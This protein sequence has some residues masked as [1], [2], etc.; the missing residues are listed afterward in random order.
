M[1][2]TET[3]SFP[4]TNH[5]ALGGFQS[6][7]RFHGRNHV[8]SLAKSAQNFSKFRFALRWTEAFRT[9]ALFA[10]PFGDGN[11]RFSR[12]RASRVLG[13]AV[14][15]GRIARPVESGTFAALTSPLRP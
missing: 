9:C 2:L 4:P 11:F 10:K 8:S 3:F 12:R 13:G 14:T 5:F 15:A 1:Q 7:T 6:R